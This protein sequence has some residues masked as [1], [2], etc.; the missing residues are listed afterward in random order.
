M[1][2]NIETMCLG[3]V[4]IQGGKCLDCPHGEEDTSCPNYIPINPESLELVEVSPGYKTGL[5]R[6]VDRYGFNWRNKINK[7]EVK[8]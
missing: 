5:Q 3:H 8:A 1:S 4:R 6:F 2:D 7:K